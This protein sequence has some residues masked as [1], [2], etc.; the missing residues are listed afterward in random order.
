MSSPTDRANE[1]TQPGYWIVWSMV[2]IFLNVNIGGGIYGSTL[3]LAWVIGLWIITDLKNQG[4]Q[5]GLATIAILFLIS[6]TAA[7]LLGNTNTDLRTYEELGKILLLLVGTMA[8]KKIPQT[9]YK[10]IV[11]WIPV[12]IAGL[13]TITYISGNGNTY[14][15]LRFSIPSIGSSNTLGYCLAISLLMAHFSWEQTNSRVKRLL[16]IIATLILGLALLATL[17]RGGV[18]QYIAGLIVFTKRKW[19]ALVGIAAILTTTVLLF[20]DSAENLQRLSTLL[21]FQEIQ[22]GSGG[23]RLYIWAHLIG[24]LITDPWHFFVGFAPGSIAVRQQQISSGM[25][26]ISAHSLYV[27]TLYSFGIIG[28]TLGIYWMHRTFRKILRSSPEDPW[29]KLQWG[30]FATI[31]VGGF[32]D[33]YIVTAQLLWLGCLVFAILE[34]DNTKQYQMLKS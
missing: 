12:G 32:F 2:C 9:T 17:S 25:V 24:D 5:T 19:M 3:C 22:Q 8:L 6:L 1:V 18:I 27:E 13:A 15:P 28:A 23:T 29:R 7:G 26:V 20:P 16:I 21:D 30:L 31:F 33:S 4:A 34:M 10:S 11:F 14:D